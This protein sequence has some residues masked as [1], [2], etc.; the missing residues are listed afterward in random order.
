MSSELRRSRRRRV[1]VCET[2]K[3]EPSLF[4]TEQKSSDVNVKCKYVLS[5]TLALQQTG[6]K[7]IS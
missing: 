6:L 3:S 4:A 7:L 2:S 1:T 5:Q